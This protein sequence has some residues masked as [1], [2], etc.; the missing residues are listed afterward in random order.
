MPC[1]IATYQA[2]PWRRSKPSA[3]GLRKPKMRCELFEA[4]KLMRWWSRAPRVIRY[5]RSLAR[6]A[7]T[8]SLWRR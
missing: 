5:L 3:H 7:R 2:E 8:A 4:A 1:D 6:S